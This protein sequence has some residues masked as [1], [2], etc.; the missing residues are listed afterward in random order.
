MLLNIAG[1]CVG[2]SSFSFPGAMMGV[3]D[4]PSLTR[5]SGRRGTAPPGERL[6]RDRHADAPAPLFAGRARRTMATLDRFVS[7]RQPE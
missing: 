7:L 6:N 4:I 2:I 5:D 1:R 3:F